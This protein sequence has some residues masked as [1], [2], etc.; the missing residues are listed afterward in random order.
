MGIKEQIKKIMQFKY[1]GKKYMVY[2]ITA[3]ILTFSSC[4]K[5]IHG[6]VSCFINSSLGDRDKQT[7]LH[8]LINGKKLRVARRSS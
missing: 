4:C 6:V 2:E 1:R 8:R 3:D 7:E 5:N